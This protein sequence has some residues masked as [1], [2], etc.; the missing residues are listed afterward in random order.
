MEVEKPLKAFFMPPCTKY[1]RIQEA[2]QGDIF[3]KYF[4]N[5]EK[6]INEILK[7]AEKLLRN[8]EKY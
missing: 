7:N 1:K 2:V 3:R 8:A 5:A 6:Y 4:R